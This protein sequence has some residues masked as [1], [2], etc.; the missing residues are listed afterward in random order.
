MKRSTLFVA[1]ALCALSLATF[2][3]CASTGGPKQAL[4]DPSDA[5]AS[6]QVSGMSCPQCANNIKLILD[7]AEGV[8][9]SRVD[10]GS[11]RVFIDFSQGGALTDAQIEQL[12]KDA[13]FTPGEVEQVKKETP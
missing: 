7:D 12:I 8:E 3:G 10:L 13:G 11:G 1:S 2:A 6:V 4:L 9:N 5:D